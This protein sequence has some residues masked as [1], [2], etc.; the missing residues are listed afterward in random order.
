MSSSPIIDKTSFAIALVTFFFS[1]WFFYKDTALFFDSFFAAT[2]AAGV[3][4]GTYM[5]FRLCM[6]AFRR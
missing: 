2:L 1:L 5:V 4:W 3:I 6:L